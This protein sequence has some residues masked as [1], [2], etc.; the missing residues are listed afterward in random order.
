M[1]RVKEEKGGL[2]GN[3]LIEHLQYND[4][5]KIIATNCLLLVCVSYLSSVKEGTLAPILKVR[6]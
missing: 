6:D 2:V 3:I 1:K 5:K 4:C